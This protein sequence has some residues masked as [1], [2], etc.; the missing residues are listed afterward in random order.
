MAKISFLCLK[1]FYLIDRTLF[2][3]FENYD[4]ALKNQICLINLWIE[5]KHLTCRLC[6]GLELNGFENHNCIVLV[7]FVVCDACCF[8]SLLQFVMRDLI[9]KNAWMF[10]M[11]MWYDFSLGAQLK[12]PFCSQTEGHGAPHNPEPNSTQTPW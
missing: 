6:I 8:F 1:Y 3:K 11:M 4:N 5:Q 2:L 10:D 7:P 9:Q 12:G